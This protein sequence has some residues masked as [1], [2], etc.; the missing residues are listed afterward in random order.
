MGLSPGTKLG[1]FS[2]VRQLGAGAMGE[3]YLAEDPDIERQV[4]IKTV[5]L[6]EHES[7]EGSAGT[8]LRLRL[9]REAKAAGR[10]VH[11][12]IVT[13]F[14][15]GESEG[16]YYLVFEYIEGTDLASR[17]RRPPALELAEILRIGRETAAAL[18]AAHRVGIVHRDIKPANILLTRD[19]AVKVGDFGI[20]ALTGQ[21][22]HLTQTGS[23][24]GTPQYLSP[25]QVRSELPLDGRSDL[26]SLGVMLYELLGGK[27]PFEGGS[28]AALLYEIVMAEP[29]HL[30]ELRPDL[31]PRLT[32][33]VMRLLEKDPGGRF[34]SAGEL[35]DELARIERG[36]DDAPAAVTAVTASEPA[37]TP[38]LD[39]AAP[40]LRVD[41]SEPQS[42]RKGK[43]VAIA[44]VATLVLL[45][46]VSATII[47]FGFPG[48]DRPSV[49]RKMPVEPVTDS[50][51]VPPADVATKEEPPAGDRSQA[52]I[53]NARPEPV[54]QGPAPRIVGGMVT[55]RVRPEDAAAGAVVK[56]DGLV[57]GLAAGSAMTLRPGRHEIVI[58]A[59]G[60][61]LETI[62]VDARGGSST[63]TEIDVVMTRNR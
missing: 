44:A 53:T 50:T 59:P 58:T 41:A 19:G 2:V 46:G 36:L 17:M 60:F 51:P 27:R 18:D 52:T 8:H 43:A 45:G 21:G 42:A 7:L 23:V 22:A 57:R 55:F 24:I 49:E 1:R 62:V 10:L 25:E 29:R 54:D 26:F 32:A 11:P 12:N 48:K 14:E 15:A 38:R 40:M 37:P 34:A 39:R 30:G 13:L 47:H 63:P 16:L 28:V 56:I 61:M 9:Q 35:R 3:V 4:A 31:P 20:A 33:T 5:R 6:A